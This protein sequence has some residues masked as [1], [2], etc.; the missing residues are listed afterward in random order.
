MFWEFMLIVGFIKF[1]KT[2][3]AKHYPISITG[4]MTT[5]MLAGSCEQPSLLTLKL[6]PV[7]TGIWGTLAR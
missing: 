7:K 6:T 3:Q 1:R 2:G 4:T 5:S